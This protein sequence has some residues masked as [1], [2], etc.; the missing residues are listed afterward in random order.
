[1][2]P[3]NPPAGEREASI[4][5]RIAGQLLALTLFLSVGC[6]GDALPA[7]PDWPPL[8]M[9]YEMTST[10]GDVEEGTLKYR[11]SYHSK[12]HWREDIIAAPPLVSPVGTFVLQGRYEIV[13]DG[14]LVQYDPNSD[15][16]Y[17]AVLEGRTVPMPG[18][19]NI[20][21]MPL[22]RL[23]R[24]YGREPVAVD[25]D[26]RVCFRDVCEEDARGWSFDLKQQHVYAD[27][28]RGIPIRLDTLDITEV[29]VNDVQ[30]PYRG[31]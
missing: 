21:P 28:L 30:E 2:L 7:E 15:E 6:Q 11:L 27:D 17:T 9:Y 24:I 13:R 25:T 14:L 12:D 4:I 5:A 8:T 1:M 3:R 26:T 22:E 18:L 16:V 31:K 29:L 20:S 10:M 23:K 19:G